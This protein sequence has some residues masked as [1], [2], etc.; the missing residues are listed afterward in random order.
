M[1]NMS[2]LYTRGLKVKYEQQYNQVVKRLKCQHYTQ[3]AKRITMST[4]YTSGLKVKYV[5][6]IHKWLK[7]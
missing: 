3:V 1:L 2:T 6:I 4:L 7:G 5:N